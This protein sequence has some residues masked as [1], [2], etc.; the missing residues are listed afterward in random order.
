MPSLW[1]E[2]LR[3]IAPAMDLWQGILGEWGNEKD[4][5]W[6]NHQHNPPNLGL[7]GSRVGSNIHFPFESPLAI[8]FLVYFWSFY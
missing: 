5:R 4:Y 6:N 8:H 3:T 2:G 1:Q 7:V